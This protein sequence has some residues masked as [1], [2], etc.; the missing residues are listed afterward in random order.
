V[1][2]FSDNSR[3]KKFNSSDLKAI[4]KLF[5]YKN[6]LN[7]D[8]DKSVSIAYSISNWLNT[9]IILRFSISVNYFISSFLIWLLDGRENLENN[10]NDIEIA[11]YENFFLI[12]YIDRGAISLHSANFIV[13]RVT[14]EIAS[15]NYFWIYRIR[16]GSFFNIYF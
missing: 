7:I 5:W 3:S 15:T 10:E 1:L 13:D 14:I 12:N 6:E 9:V 11:D 4:L 2:Y 16:S 8:S